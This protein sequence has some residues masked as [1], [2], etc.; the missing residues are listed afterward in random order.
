M[1]WLETFV[2]E[3]GAWLGVATFFI[4]AFERLARITPTKTDD[5]IVGVFHKIFSV[6]G[7]NVPDNPGKAGQ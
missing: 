6:L 3:Y 5:A 4:A 2:A 7:V 1:D